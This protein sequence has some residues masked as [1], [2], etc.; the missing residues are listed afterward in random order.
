MATAVVVGAAGG[1]GK[2]ICTA[3]S[4]SLDIVTFDK[5]DEPRAI[6]TTHLVLANGIT[7]AGW[8]ETI[9][10]N[11]TI[12]HE[13]AASCDVTDSIT[14][15]GS[16]ATVLGFPDNP[17][18]QASKAGL[19]GLMRS[20]AY[21]L[22]PSGVRVNVVSPGYI[23]APMTSRSYEERHD[24]IAS[25]TLLNRWGEPEEIAN[26]VAFLCSDKASYVTGQ[27]LIIDGGWSIKGM[28]TE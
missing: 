3:L 20:L 22:G 15:I 23:R 24:F 18:Y 9:Y 10:N 28:M 5:D 11:L 19:L 14:F 26:V 21:D 7:G 25:H 27:N 2:A 13:W 4:E 16:L 1:I 6:Q 8:E 12:S 17:S